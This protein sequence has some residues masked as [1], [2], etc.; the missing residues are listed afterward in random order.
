VLRSPR[1]VFVLTA[2]G[3]IAAYPAWPD[4]S[5]LES[6]SVAMIDLDHFKRFNDELGHQAGDRMLRAAAAACKA[7]L[8]T[9]DQIAR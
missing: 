5:L 3:A 6:L 9:A 4:G 1:R 8:S 2:I 7:A